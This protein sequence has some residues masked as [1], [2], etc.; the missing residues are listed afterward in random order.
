MV[1]SLVGQLIADTCNGMIVVV[2]AERGLVTASWWEKNGN[3]AVL[4]Y[5]LLI[6]CSR[7]DSYIRNM[8][9]IYHLD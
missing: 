5:P 4:S 2:E 8:R 1:V 7:L 6:H 9:K 3:N